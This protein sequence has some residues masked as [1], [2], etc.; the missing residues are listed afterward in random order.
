MVVV[1]WESGL[2]LLLAF[3]VQCLFDGY[4]YSWMVW[5]Y[6]CTKLMN[7]FVLSWPVRHVCM[8]FWTQEGKCKINCKNNSF[9]CLPVSF[10]ALNK[11]YYFVYFFFEHDFVILI[12]LYFLSSAPISE[13]T[14]LNG[15]SINHSSIYAFVKFFS[16]KAAKRAK[17][18]ISGKRLLD[19]QFLKASF[20]SS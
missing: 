15:N 5:T 14:T 11:R 6:I 18:S 12:L 3:A 2:F 17:E 8:L 4:N 16:A 9:L 13:E 7:H 10:A 19:G 20:S 1:S